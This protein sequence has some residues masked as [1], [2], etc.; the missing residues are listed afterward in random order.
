NAIGTW[1]RLKPSASASTLFGR[2]PNTGSSP[3]A[4]ATPRLSTASAASRCSP[5]APEGV[6]Y[7]RSQAY[8][9]PRPDPAVPGTL[10]RKLLPSHGETDHRYETGGRLTI[11]AAPVDNGNNVEALHGYKAA[12]PDHSQTAQF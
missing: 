10:V 5:T 1:M 8:R 4:P 9:D 7:D 6:C 2:T 12:L 11:P 3:T